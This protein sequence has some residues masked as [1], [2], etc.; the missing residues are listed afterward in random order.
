M[1][2]CTVP[3]YV[4]NNYWYV[5]VHIYIYTHTHTYIHT[6]TH[7]YIHIHTPTHTYI[8]VCMCAC[9][10]VAYLPKI[11]CVLNIAPT[12]CL[13]SLR[14]I[15]FPNEMYSV[16][17]AVEFNCCRQGVCL[18]VSVGSIE[19]CSKELFIPSA[20][21]SCISWYFLWLFISCLSYATSCDR[22]II[23]DVLGSI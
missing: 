17:D 21:K 3:S 8:C 10:C 11:R 19:V 6:Y 22:V 20:M 12:L 5:R 2:V 15:Y 7:T 1:C 13:G 14:V 23:N 4:E 18:S 16:H 9:V